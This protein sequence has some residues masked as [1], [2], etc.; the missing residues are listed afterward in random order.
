M[1]ALTGEDRVVRATAADA[2]R[3][4]DGTEATVAFSQALPS[5]EPDVQVLLIRAL[6]DR[7]DRAALTVVAQTAG[8]D[9]ATVRLVALEALAL[10]GD[11]STVPLLAC[12][13]AGTDN[14]EARIALSSLNRLKGADVDG[15]IL[16]MVSATEGKLKTVLI[17]GLSSRFAY[18]AVPE[19]LRQLQDRDPSIREAT[20]TALGTLASEK[21]LDT[22]VN[23]LMQEQDAEVQRAAESAIVSTASRTRSR[24]AAAESLLAAYSATSGNARARCSL[25]RVMGQVGHESTLAVLNEATADADPAVRDAAIRALAVWPTPAPIEKL[26]AIAERP[27]NERLGAVALE[28]YVRLLG[29]P[30]ERSAAET[31]RLYEKGLSLASTPQ[32]KRLALIGLSE[33]PHSRAVDIIKRY[34]NDRDVAEDVARAFEKIKNRAF[35]TGTA[36][37]IS[38]FTLEFEEGGILK[39][40][41]KREGT[42]SVSENTLTVSSSLG[43]VVLEI[44]KGGVFLG[45]AELKRL[46]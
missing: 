9:D 7:G 2:V 14:D 19:L 10:L 20:F 45:T 28:A 11:A 5:L 29:L 32:Q 17:E 42:W 6:A 31:V 46:R 26:Y 44:R 30:S 41:G 43:P 40:N 39:L 34:E 35:L 22:L 25:V 3:H 8:G 23:L 4:V 36:W 38:G 33:V 1:E 16:H 18:G 27:P 21:A 15:A 13:A 24:A 37:Q 12:A